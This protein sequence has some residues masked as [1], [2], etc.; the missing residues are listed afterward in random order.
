[1]TPL[2]PA[3]LIVLVCIAHMMTLM[4]VFAFPALLPSFIADWS[5]TNAEAGWI[6]GIPL[7]A[8]AISVSILVSLTDRIDARLIFGGGALLAALS[9]AGF[10][11]FAEGFWSA[12]ALR[13]LAGVGM[14]ATYMPGLR[15]LVDRYR[16]DAQS[17]SVAL[18]TASFS[19]GTALSFLVSGEVGGALGW[20][21]AFWVSCAAAL[22]SAVLILPLNAIV[23]Q[24]PDNPGSVLDIR[25]VLRNHAAM[26]FVLAYAAHGWEL[27]ALRAWMVA[28]LVF[29]LSLQPGGE[30]WPAPTVIAT[31]GALVA[32]VCSVA[33]NEWAERYGRRRMVVI[34]LLSGASMAM[35]IGFLPGLP[36]LVVATLILVYCGLVQL[37]SASLTAGAVQAAEPGRRGATLGVHS[38]VGFAGSA[39][40]PLAVGIVLDATGGGQSIAS[41]GA[42][43][44]AMGAVGLIA[45]FAFLLG[46]TART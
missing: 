18:Y 10:A 23:P 17:R 38:L 15:V 20:R 9:L 34:Y 16:G 21:A 14:A 44:I 29:S 43:F 37:D 24:R 30:G 4:G 22:L 35:V 19:L 39:V 25:P 41:W 13:A 32:M 27:F 40:A 46:R 1:V 26:A 5:L 31:L 8:N 42:G 11:L 28:F 3:V 33:G 45:P 6:S 36:Y 12:L 7:A 2:R